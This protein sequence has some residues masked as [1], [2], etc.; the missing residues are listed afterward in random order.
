MNFIKNTD[1]AIAEICLVDEAKDSDIIEFIGS[2]KVCYIVMLL[3]LWKPFILIFTQI[4]V[5]HL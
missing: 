1:D 2:K 3:Y 4:I 5:K